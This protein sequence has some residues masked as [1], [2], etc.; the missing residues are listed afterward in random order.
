MKAA[1]MMP[2]KCIERDELSWTAK[3]TFLNSTRPHMPI[4]LLLDRK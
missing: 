3:A 2:E 4:C 1:A